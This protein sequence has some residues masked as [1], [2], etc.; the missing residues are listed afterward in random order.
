M[1]TFCRCPHSRSG[2]TS[3][4]PFFPVTASISLPHAGQGVWDTLSCTKLSV[5]SFTAC[6]SSFVYRRMSA[7]KAAG[8]AFSRLMASS[9][10]SHLAVSSGSF[11]S[12]APG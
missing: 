10:C 11:R 7:R 8:S 1:L 2:Q 5:L 9:F 6:T 4:R 3:I 12:G